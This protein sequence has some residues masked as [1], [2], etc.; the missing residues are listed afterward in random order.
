M[1]RPEDADWTELRTLLVSGAAVEAVRPAVI[2]AARSGGVLALL[3]DR[4]AAVAASCADEL[5]REA[6]GQMH[7]TLAV[8][9][10][11][12]CLDKIGVHR[13]ALLKGNATGLLLYSVPHLRVTRDVDILVEPEDF[14]R[15]IDGLR[16]DGWVDASAPLSVAA[17]GERPF[18]LCFDRTFGDVTLQC[19]VHQRLVSSDTVR[20]DHGSIL[21]RAASHPDSPL[22]LCHSEDLFLG[23][24]LHAAKDSFDVPLKSWLDLAL[25]AD[26]PQ[27]SLERCAERAHQ[28]SMANIT[29]A[30]LVVLQ[31]W[32]MVRVPEPVL[33]DLRPAA[34]I[35][36]ALDLA[37]SGRGSRA[38]TWPRH[39]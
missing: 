36:R 10:I 23:G 15:V 8:R 4:C 3:A 20:I 33:T 25:L 9:S 35:A 18:E 17:F 22:P 34:P 32:K 31:R 7:V 26:H 19:D 14:Q 6:M 11:G 38:P 27:V 12:D 37:L 30:C 24:V 29:W 2:A 5:A 21:D 28:W 16:E 39:R 13:V 1:G